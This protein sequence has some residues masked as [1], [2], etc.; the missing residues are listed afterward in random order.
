MAFPNRAEL[1]GMVNPAAKTE[2]DLDDI[3]PVEVEPID[4]GDI[5]GKLPETPEQ[6]DNSGWTW[7]EE[8]FTNAQDQYVESQIAALDWEAEQAKPWYAKG[9][10]GVTLNAL[11]K[12]LA[13]TTSLLKEVTDMQQGQGFSWTDF[14]TQVD[15]NYTF[16]RYIHEEMNWM[17][18]VSIGGWKPV[19]NIVGFIGDVAF[20]P[21]TFLGLVGKGG[22]LAGQIARTGG[23]AAARSVI[24]NG[25]DDLL[26][27]VAV[28]GDDAVE[29]AVKRWANDP[30]AAITLKSQ[31][32]AVGDV[33]FKLDD[34]VRSEV[35]FIREMGAKS[36]PSQISGPDL[37]RIGD[38]Y[39]RYG[40]DRNGLSALDDGFT[41]A[42][43]EAGEK[44]GWEF[45]IKMPFTGMVG[46]GI[47][48][49]VAKRIGRAPSY[50][51]KTLFKLVS[52]DTRA[53]D[54]F[55]RSPMT[56]ARLAGRKA[57]T[58]FHRVTGNAF[59]GRA[60]VFKQTIAEG[61]GRHGVAKVLQAKEGLLAVGRG[62]AKGR[63]AEVAATLRASET[64]RAA[65]REG[66]DETDIYRAMG[67]DTEVLGRV[68]PELAEDLGVV[69]DD[70]KTIFHDM[71]GE[72]FIGD[73]INYVP[74]IPQQEVLDYLAKNGG[75]GRVPRKFGHTKA[76]PEMQRTYLS[77]SEFKE[78][79]RQF[80][81]DRA[82]TE[83]AGFSDEILGH[84]LYDIGEINPRT[85]QAASSVEVQINEIFKDLDI[86]YEMFS[87]NA[88]VAVGSYIKAMS[89]RV[90]E[91]HAEH[92]LKQTGQFQPQW[93]YHH[94]PP[95]EGVRG[96]VQQ[97]KRLET[98]RAIAWK[99]LTQA[100]ADEVIAGK[101]A[102]VAALKARR[103]KLQEDHNAAQAK[104]AKAEAELQAKS[105]ELIA[106]DVTIQ[107]IE[108]ELAKLDTSKNIIAAEA[109]RQAI[110]R[111]LSKILTTE[112]S[113]DL[114]RHMHDRVR[115]ISVTQ[116][117]IQQKLSYY[118]N[119]LDEA[120]EIIGRIGRG[121]VEDGAV[122]TSR[123][124]Y[125][126]D[127]IEDT[128][129][130][131]MDEFADDPLADWMV[132]D[133]YD[134]FLGT[135]HVQNPSE[136]GHNVQ[137]FMSVLE[138]FDAKMADAMQTFDTI[139]GHYG[140]DAVGGVAPT[141]KRI[142]DATKNVKERINM[143]G[144][145]DILDDLSPELLADL[146][147][148]ISSL[149]SSRVANALRPDN[150]LDRFLKDA[151]E[152]LE[153]RY[154]YLDDVV[155]GSDI[156]STKI[157]VSDGI[158]GSIEINFADYVYF[159][160][161]KEEL[162]AGIH[163]VMPVHRTSID[164]ILQKGTLIKSSE[165]LGGTFNGGLYSYNN[166]G[167]IE[168][169]YVKEYPNASQAYA[170]SAANAL[171]RGMGLDAP[172]SYVSVGVDG[173]TFHIAPW[174]D[175]STLKEIDD[176][177]E[178]VISAA[179]ES[180][181]KNAVEPF[182][183]LHYGVD[184]GL[185]VRAAVEEPINI[186]DSFYNSRGQKAAPSGE[187]AIRPY[188]TSEIT[189]ILR[190]RRVETSAWDDV[191]DLGGGAAKGSTKNRDMVAN[192]TRGEDAAARELGVQGEFTPLSDESL[193]YHVLV[194]GGEESMITSTF[195]VHHDD[196]QVPVNP[197]HYDGT[198]P[199]MMDWDQKLI[200]AR[201]VYIHP[202]T[203]DVMVMSDN[204]A[205][206]RGWDPQDPAI[207]RE[208]PDGPQPLF[209]EHYN[210]LIFPEHLPYLIPI[211]KRQTWRS[212]RKPLGRVLQQ[213]EVADRLV[214]LNPVENLSDVMVS[215]AGTRISR[216]DTGNAFGYG[217]V[218]APKQTRK[219][220]TDAKG[221]SYSPLRMGNAKAQVQRMIHLRTQHGGWEE[222]LRREVRGIPE[223]DIKILATQLEG[224]SARMA[225]EAGLPYPK[226]DELAE[227]KN[228]LIV[229]HRTSS[230]FWGN[231]WRG[232]G[233]ENHQFI[234]DPR[235]TGYSNHSS[236]TH[237]PDKFGTNFTSG[238]VN[239]AL[240]GSI[241]GGAVDL[242]GEHFVRRLESFKD[243]ALADGSGR[244]LG[245]LPEF[246]NGELQRYLREEAE[247][248]RQANPEILEGI[249]SGALE[250]RRRANMPLRVTK[251]DDI[252][253]LDPKTGQPM[254]M[255]DI[256]IDEG[257]PLGPNFQPTVKAELEL[258]H[259]NQIKVFGSHDP[260]YVQNQ[261]L[262]ESDEISLVEAM[263]K[264]SRE[265]YSMGGNPTQG[266][267]DL[268]TYPDGT[269]WKAYDPDNSMLHTRQAMNETW[270]DM[271]T[272]ISDDTFELLMMHHERTLKEL[273]LAYK[274]NKISANWI[275]MVRYERMVNTVRLYKD[276]ENVSMVT[277]VLETP[278]ERLLFASWL[279]ETPPKNDLN[280]AG[281]D[282][283][284]KAM[285]RWTEGRFSSTFVD[286]MTSAQRRNLLN[287]YRLQYDPRSL[288]A[289]PRKRY[290]LWELGAQHMR[291][292][293]ATDSRH[294]GLSF[295]FPDNLR[296]GGWG[297]PSQTKST[298]WDE[299]V[300]KDIYNIEPPSGQTEV[301]VPEIEGQMRFKSD[302]P[303]LKGLSAETKRGTRIYDTIYEEIRT[304][305]RQD[306]YVGFVWANSYDTKN[307]A[308]Q[309]MDR[310]TREGVNSGRI[311]GSTPTFVLTDPMALRPRA[312]TATADLPLGQLGEK[313]M[314]DGIVADVPRINDEF[315]R[316]LREGD[317]ANAPRID[318]L[319]AEITNKL[320]VNFKNR[321][322]V[323]RAVNRSK[324]TVEQAK[325][326]KRQ[327]EELY[328][329]KT[330]NKKGEKILDELQREIN[331]LEEGLENLQ[332][333][334]RII[335]DVRA[336][337]TNHPA[338][339]TA[340]E[341]GDRGLQDLESI[342]Q[343]I[344]ILG[345]QFFL[346]EGMS[347]EWLDAI[348]NRA[349]YEGEGSIDSILARTVDHG[350]PIPADIELSD[351]ANLADEAE[352]FH[353][354]GFKP[355]GNS[356]G[357][358]FMVEVMAAETRF[359]ATG[360]LKTFLKHY[361]RLHNLLKGYQIAKTGFHLRNAYGGFF[362]NMLHGID[363]ASYRQFR[364]AVK[365][366]RREG[367]DA[368]RMRVPPEHLAIVKQMDEAGLLAQGAGQVAAEFGNTA[369][370]VA[371][372]KIPLK[373]LRKNFSPF[374]SQNLLLRSSRKAGTW[375]ESYLRGSLAFDTLKKGRTVDDAFE[376][377]WRYHF[378]YDD[379]SDFER[380]VV[381]RVIPFYTWTRKVTPLMIEELIKNPSK[382]QRIN[383]VRNN[384]VA[385]DTEQ[386]RYVPE[387]MLESGGFQIPYE[388]EG[389]NLW[390]VPDLPIKTPREVL[391]PVIN[392]DTSMSVSDRLGR[393][394]EVLGSQVTPLLK[395][396]AELW[397]NR[398]FFHGYEFSEEYQVVPDVFQRVPLL[399]EAMNTIG[400][401]DKSRSGNW[402]MKDD[403]L[404]FMASFLPTL[405]DV[406]RLFPSEE[407]YQQRTLSTWMSF[408]FGLGIRT[409]TEWEQQRARNAEEWDKRQDQKDMDDL[410]RN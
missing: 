350:K 56:G 21:L 221:R 285:A 291:V 322:E 182:E 242:T 402:M 87:E 134:A 153:R 275:P 37:N 367:A 408:M 89:R 246:Q 353:A 62:A 179:I 201:D 354:A 224:A 220:V 301:W 30:S 376:N 314:L 378:D 92:L 306:G 135:Q 338:A 299:G 68:T 397:G 162:E 202:T 74:R 298:M 363:T 4:W 145:D 196:A 35:N 198:P 250:I 102:E 236:V 186:P 281:L 233:H 245:D 43:F 133:E 206:W 395:S 14:K 240:G 69:M 348:T 247:V 75:L 164:E 212:T 138:G 17:E 382:F 409:N 370:T 20:D 366:Y 407:K 223:E 16:G 205:Q 387:W 80:G 173:K 55:I 47:Y 332:E 369:L 78:K 249:E 155:E 165:E 274:E 6:P 356:M 328:S 72:E 400:W 90:T 252:V 23:A 271:G 95:T 130:K 39:G 357:P 190:L 83:A 154:N 227:A 189:H 112:D 70:L 334:R 216:I 27:R 12:P 255:N 323:A 49:K 168:N 126:V 290:E 159:K 379:L 177:S 140:I 317:A 73:V 365:H 125:Q 406:R 320:Q 383:N 215:N 364:R 33:V 222:F 398:Q 329:G 171:Y 147:V 93:L 114:F 104:V 100:T 372:K 141:P 254:S 58:G 260:T 22:A 218:K 34:A 270:V 217:S 293:H 251:Y 303:N 284:P 404:H 26:R 289:D 327:I 229:T 85:G 53:G 91:V 267:T 294:S 139:A 84:K 352:R 127:E 108:A 341:L 394:V 243:H 103:L 142:R 116:I 1:A 321:E 337:P 82:K 207:A 44:V 149:G 214:G 355:I 166:G 115:A 192:P 42:W 403:R 268:K 316:L 170:E 385:Q 188:T 349:L 286:E 347:K 79:A 185:Q 172:A 297:P 362:N 361:D 152:A 259:I 235:I 61:A 40:L 326:Q 304:S 41:K 244:T 311:L 148:Y 118:F 296:D 64:F 283:N 344:E 194:E 211:A 113:A 48:N 335:D 248:I 158:G 197:Y 358:E 169:V 325:R 63:Q 32:P 128:V 124:V 380:G 163:S 241:G 308:F 234:F 9:M 132:L 288:H 331:E 66:L 8:Q 146:D 339:V 151:K 13:A 19:D 7:T 287:E 28:Y 110:A 405:G 230:G 360:R 313:G 199:S 264:Q 51:P 181:G 225:E 193:N 374:S 208:G 292:S 228:H 76:G 200:L 120:Y 343:A 15:E 50:E 187:N 131:I 161:L 180:S 261:M 59:N 295:L 318:P 203:G 315:E 150:N 340:R 345:H 359:Q 410:Y 99:R 269:A 67:G 312:G 231:S 183:G 384:I 257:W 346:K 266:G 238:D 24:R 94:K 175:G 204:P 31:N 377:V 96:A 219:P 307:A 330:R 391:D 324:R 38:I 18:D 29:N 282:T 336:N 81:G 399:M 101:G 65:R 98:K 122:T 371:G 386:P 262:V 137:G 232:D 213:G 258:E 117:R 160:S 263:G 144:K 310:A 300:Q 272:R 375:V 129:A 3:E 52:S 237:W 174:V 191:L 396:P 389:E 178:G 226:I 279:S 88:S 390:M 401:A 157:D 256:A 276:L 77:P 123:G 167:K 45:G 106:K 265:E 280:L 107:E 333:A 381:K 119:D 11:Q 71:A 121:E 2:I 10:I 305:F 105:E 36:R 60:G 5:V 278:T 351:I 319:E 111:K 239:Y 54:L 57:T 209:P 143:I 156:G 25:S 253:I 277:D 273:K 368:G 309:V 373:T 109:E 136:V 86:G 46:R 176:V 97:L 195:K 392:T 302:R 393:A 184:E 210:G 388:V 342:E